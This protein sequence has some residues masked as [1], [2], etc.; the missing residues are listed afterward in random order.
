MALACIITFIVLTSILIFSVAIAYDRGQNQITP[1]E[2][3]G[4][5]KG[6]DYSTYTFSIE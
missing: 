4:K 2:D 3:M 1:M 6:D 5:I